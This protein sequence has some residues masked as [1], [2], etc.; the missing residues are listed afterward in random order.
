MKKT[1]NLITDVQTLPNIQDAAEAIVDLHDK[2]FVQ[3]LGWGAAF[4]KDV[5]EYLE[6]LLQHFQPTRDGLWVARKG[7]EIIGTIAI[8]GR[9]D[10]PECARLRIFVVDYNYH[11]QGIGKSL[12]NQ[13]IAFCKTIGYKKIEL[14]TFDNLYE[15][16]A[17]YLKYGFRIIKEREVNYWGSQ[18]REQLFCL[19]LNEPSS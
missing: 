6:E 19:V 8:D 1:H 9:I 7:E 14:W 3:Q 11:R 12:L 2:Y 5:K 15:A 18:L 10:G 13:A 4:K 17:L 16:K